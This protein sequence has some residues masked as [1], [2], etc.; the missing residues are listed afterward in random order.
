MQLLLCSSYDEYGF[1]RGADFDVASHE[2]F[3]SSYLPVLV[4]R[5]QRWEAAYSASGGEERSA[6]LKRFVRKGIPNRRELCAK[7][8][9][10]AKVYAFGADPHP[11]MLLKGRYLWH[12]FRA[13]H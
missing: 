1:V 9:I 4:R 12:P 2:E 6:R 3:M 5:G 13:A 10:S 8:L 11:K 7:L